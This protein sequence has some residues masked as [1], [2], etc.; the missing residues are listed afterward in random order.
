MLDSLLNILFHSKTILWV[1]F[2]ISTVSQMK[3]LRFQEVKCEMAFGKSQ[4]PLP[5]LR[6]LTF[7]F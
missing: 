4:I 2:I 1:G 7:L 3:K 6:D 5:L